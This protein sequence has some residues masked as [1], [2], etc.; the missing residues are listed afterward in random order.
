MTPS[1]ILPDLTLA[2]VFALAAALVLSICQCCRGQVSDPGQASF[3]VVVAESDGTSYGSSTAI[4]PR[5]VI[6]NA[7]VCPTLRRVTL[8][9]G[10][11]GQAWTAE[12]VAIDPA[13]DL[14][15]VVTT[16]GSEP[17]PWVHMSRRD[18][19]VG[20]QVSLWGYGK[21]GTLVSMRAKVLPIKGYRDQSRKV[22]VIETTTRLQQ[23]DSGG[24]MFSAHGELV[25]V[26]WGSGWNSASSPVSSVHALCRY[27]TERFPEI[28]LFDCDGPFC[29][30]R[31]PYQPPAER[32]VEPVVP[33]PTP[34]PK[35]PSPAPRQPEPQPELRPSQYPPAPPSSPDTG[36]GGWVPSA[37]DLVRGGLTAIGVATGLGIP[38]WL[39]WIGGKAGGRALGAWWD[40]RGE[41]KTEKLAE[42]VK[43]KIA[44]I[45]PS[46][47]G[48]AA[49][50]GGPGI[51]SAR[52]PV[53][54]EEPEPAEDEEPTVLT[55]ESPRVIVV[56]VE[57]KPQE[58]QVVKQTK[59][60]EVEKPSAELAAYKQALD[61]IATGYPGAADWVRQVHAFKD[62]ILAGQGQKPP[63]E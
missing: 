16:K 8:L 24:G 40:A 15:L 45:L 41:A 54:S 27:Y 25:A 46:V 51:Q 21:Q 62:Q 50:S 55:E 32:P 4:H 36:A 6:T 44:G 22:P 34:E 57:G 5:A 35:Q 17:L 39:L 9:H 53:D 37:E 2:A 33:T 1:R 12:A 43:T 31:R 26:D 38:G 59:Y 47:S 3:R 28:G 52:P 7:H 14:C 42:T 11:S 10:P 60:V 63:K 20:E 23:G 13:A 30:P 29:S 18:P 61:D 56:P 19:Q 48:S 49:G 58:P